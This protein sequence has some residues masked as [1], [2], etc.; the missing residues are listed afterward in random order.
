MVADREGAPEPASQPHVLP[1]HI[2]VRDTQASRWLAFAKPVLAIPHWFILI[3]VTWWMHFLLTFLIAPWVV[4]TGRYPRWLFVASEGLLRWM[5][6][7]YAYLAGFCDRYP[8]H[9]FGWNRDYPAQFH[10]D[11][12]G[13]VSRWRVVPKLVVLAAVAV[14]FIFI[15][16]GLWL[17]VWFLGTLSLMVYGRH[18]P[19]TRSVLLGSLAVYL[20]WYCFVNLMTDELHPLRWRDHREEAEEPPQP[21]RAATDAQEREAGMNVSEPSTMAP[22]PRDLFDVRTPEQ[23]PSFGDIGGMD[24]VKRELRETLQL[25]LMFP[26]AAKRYAVRWN[27]ILLHGPP[28]TGKTFL[29]QAT[30]GEF[31]M[32]FVSV[33]PS[34]LASPYRG[35]ASELIDTAFRMAGRRRPCV[36]FFDDFDGLAMKRASTPVAEERNSVNQILRSVER[37]RDVHD[38][39]IMAATNN[40]DSVDPAVVRPG[41]F[42]RSIRVDLPNEAGRTAILTALLA[43][44]PSSEIDVASLSKLMAGMSAA[45]IRQVV[46]WAALR[47]MAAETRGHEA[48]ITQSLLLDGLRAR[49][50]RDRPFAQE[51]SWEQLVLATRTKSELIQFQRFIEDPR[52]AAAFGVEPPSGLLLHGPPGTGKTTIA[53]VLAAQARASFYAISAADLMSKWVGETEE[54]IAVALRRARENCPSIVF[55]DEIDAIFP[56]RG[57]AGGVEDRWTNQLLQEIDG[58]HEHRGVFVVGATN[59]PELLDPALL[60]GGRLS[61]QI[62]IPLPDA[63][64]R[65]RLLEAFCKE[66]PLNGV[67]LGAVS[68][69]TDGFSGADLK[70]LAQDAAVKAAVRAC[71]GGEVAKVIT[72]EDFDLSL[73]DFRK[74][75]SVIKWSA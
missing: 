6:N 7:V 32:N 56:R 13:R 71:E 73:D 4:L 70:A 12:A 58:I 47:A 25:M 43:K 1:L 48:A 37:F 11:Y 5:V 60:R 72:R 42:D 41:R 69:R 23:L 29:A 20:Q 74:Q 64:G 51:W 21:E 8:P 26:D 22:H 44:R 31:G 54:N 59:R 19:W 55:L 52:L 68:S 16:H 40:L 53:K 65:Q 17:G 34:E 27:G 46:E 30:A 2:E 14:L 45:A 62:E 63:P 3:Y 66:M 57:G 39:I 18:R 61:R 10:I 49:G 67:D 75:R 15:G 28:G 36:L 50:G 24:D 38:L 35:G 33:G 9:P